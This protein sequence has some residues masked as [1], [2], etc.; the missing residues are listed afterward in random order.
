MELGIL[1]TMVEL[2]SWAD[3]EAGN[4]RA[5]DGTGPL[6]VLSKQWVCKR[7]SSAWMNGTFSCKREPEAGRQDT[8]SAW[9]PSGSLCRCANIRWWHCRG[10]IA[11]CVL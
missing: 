3:S 10:F 8:G 4:A 2:S 5:D 7:C 9:F 11:E 6:D 1:R